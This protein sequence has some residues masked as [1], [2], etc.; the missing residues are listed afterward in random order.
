MFDVFS[1]YD[2][3]ASISQLSIT[4][5]ATIIFIV[6]FVAAAMV[7]LFQEFCSDISKLLIWLIGRI[8]RM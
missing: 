8:K 4:D 3:S 7:P 1:K 6:S 2:L 5:L